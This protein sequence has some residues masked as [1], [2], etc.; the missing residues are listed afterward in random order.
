MTQ[1]QPHETPAS[2]ASQT[3][4]DAGRSPLIRAAIWV[5]IGALIAAA[6]V[7]V[8]WVLIGPE[9]GIVARAFLTVLLLA[10]F[11]GAAILDANL[12]PNRPAWLA[13]ASMGVWILILLIGAVMIWM[14]E[15]F[16]YSGFGRFVSFLLIV[17]ILQLALLHIRLFLKALARNR[18]TFTQVIAIVTIVLVI[19]LAIMLVIPLM[20]SEYAQLGDLYWRFVVSITILAAVGTALLPLINVLFAPRRPRPQPVAAPYAGYPGYPGAGGQQTGVI[21]AWAP[22]APQGQTWPGQAQAGWQAQQ[23]QTGWQEQSAGPSF[24]PSPVS[25]TPAPATAEPAPVPAS[26]A[27]AAADAANTEPPI[28]APAAAAPAPAAAAPAPAEAELLPWPMYADGRTPLPMLPDGS[29]DWQAYRS[30][31]PS[32][33]AQS[34]VPIVPPSPTQ[35]AF[36]PPAPA[37]G[38][39]GTP[40]YEGFPPPPPLPPRN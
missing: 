8:V 40:G 4:D 38:S 39:P 11:A 32:P 37:A 1:P 28:P 18:T 22:H 19:V 24:A 12:A 10:G 35:P 15:R 25:A 29:P 36:P 7:C 26:A 31:R 27:P 33:G 9:N 6:I 16:A 3:T 34:F 13:L 21:P 2:A 14:P 30:G 17:L 23:P 5:A 20:L